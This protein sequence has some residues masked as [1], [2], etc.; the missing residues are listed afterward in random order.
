MWKRSAIAGLAGLLACGV[1]A[2][3]DLDAEYDAADVEELQIK[4]RVGEI[5]LEASD[6][7]RIRVELELEP[8]DD[9][10]SEVDDLIDGAEIEVT[11]RNDRLH[12]EV[13]FPGSRHSDDDDVD[14]MEKWRVEAPARLR[15]NLEVSVGELEVNGI[16]GGVEGRVGVGET[17]INVP[18]GSV[19]LKA[20]V[21]EV[22]VR[23]GTKSVGKVD[24]D[25]NV[26]EVTLNVDG[27]Y[28]ESESSF[29]VGQ[30]LV[31]SGEG[32]DDISVRV[33]VGEIDVRVD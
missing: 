17:T 3:R 25:T 33:N 16:E 23:N 7:D 12:L 5:R 8:D 18:S 32:G 4:A 13:I 26:G 10:G 21:G 15:A 9:A 31:W 1:I 6:D 27:G 14:I 2:A 30:R 19:M 24:L 20:S 28:I 22:T 29:F 11:R